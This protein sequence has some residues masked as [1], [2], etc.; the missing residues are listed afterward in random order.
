MD[1]WWLLAGILVVLGIVNGYFNLRTMRTGEHP[2]AEIRWKQEPLSPWRHEFFTILPIALHSLGLVALTALILLSLS[3]NG[4]PSLIPALESGRTIQVLLAVLAGIGAGV[5]SLIC[6][7]LIT[8]H[9]GGPW[10][11]PVSYGAAPLGLVY[12]RRLVLWKSFSHFETDP[13]NRLIRMYSS[14]SPELVTWVIQPPVES[15]LGVLRMVQA[16]VPT[17]VAGEP[18]PFLRSH[19]VLLF[20]MAALV[21]AGLAPVLWGWFNAAAWVW[22]V[23]LVAFFLVLDLGNRLISLYEGRVD[24]PPASPTG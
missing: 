6:G 4:G 16:G 13:E 24:G 1:W 20:L 17:R 5:T 9:L 15:Y 18:A 19:W 21:A 11:R 10:I 7:T 22:G 23:A 2:A 14:F 12:G 8:F 3:R